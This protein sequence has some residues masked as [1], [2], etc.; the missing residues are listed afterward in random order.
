MT[1]VRLLEDIQN[2]PRSLLTVLD[3]Q[4]TRGRP[5]LLDAAARLRS[6]SRVVVT[7]MGASLN[8]AVPLHYALVDAGIHA[9]LVETAELLHYQQPLCAGAVVVIVSRSGESV[10]ALKVQEALQGSTIAVTNDAASTL[11]REASLHLRIAC[12]ADEIVAIQSYTGTLLALHLLAAEVRGQFHAAAGIVYR[13]LADLPSVIAFHERESQSWKGFL[14]PRVP[15]YA[16]GR[17]PSVSSAYETALLLG[18]TAKEPAIGLP[19]ATFRHGPVEIVDANFSCSRVRAARTHAGAQPGPRPRTYQTGRPSQ[20]HRPR[21]GSIGDSVLANARLPGG[22]RAAFR[23]H[24]LTI[25]RTT[26]R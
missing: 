24:S 9:S 26:P 12:L 18:E 20:S 6:A 5:A 4:S 14:E 2:Q 16:L 22:A 19:A 25:R 10:E 3:Q 17:G 8:A 15:L 11:A 23:N 21:R 7:G 1:E 13:A